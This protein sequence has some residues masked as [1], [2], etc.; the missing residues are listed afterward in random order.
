MK[1]NF[2]AEHLRIFNEEIRGQ[3]YPDPGT[4]YYSKNLSYEE[5]YNL[6]NAQRAH[7]NFL[8]M[9]GSSVLFQ[10]VGGLYFP[11]PTA[12]L[13]FILFVARLL[14]TCGYVTR[15]PKGRYFGAFLNDGIIIAHFVLACISSIYLIK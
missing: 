4:G 9:L 11:I 12:I 2:G 6:N 5:W 3:G 7:M 10:L 15:G 14:Y 13:T 8:E 1:Q